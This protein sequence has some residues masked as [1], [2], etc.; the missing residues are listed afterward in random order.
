MKIY[1]GID[2]TDSI[3]QGATGETAKQ[4]IRIIEERRWGNCQGLTRHQLLLHPDIAYTSHN[5]SMCFTAEIETASLEPL[6]E[7]AAGCL[8]R[9][10]APGSD[11]GLCVAAEEQLR[12]VES[13]IAYGYE[14][15]KRIIT[16]GEAYEL[17]GKLGVH[18][19]EHGGAGI[20]VIGALAGVGLRMTNND[21]RFQGR[22]ELKVPGAIINVTEILCSNLVERVQSVD[23]YV[24]NKNEE[25]RL[26]HKLKT[27]LLGGKRTLLVYRREGALVWKTCTNAHLEHY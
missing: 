10:S 1:V 6:I 27:V 26:G 16:K 11:P 13:L 8:E 3:E 15:K 9:D 23:G 25:V 22:L 19:S 18:L 7:A 2:D 17:A 5:S 24:L 20:G 14:T 12:D 21:G 4:I